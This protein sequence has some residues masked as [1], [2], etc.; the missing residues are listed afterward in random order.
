VYIDEMKEY[1]ELRRTEKEFLELDEV[2]DDM[3][4]SDDPWQ[5]DEGIEEALELADEMEPYHSVEI[6]GKIYTKDRL[7]ED[8]QTAQ[9][10]QDANLETT[11]AETIGKI[12]GNNQEDTLEEQA[13]VIEEL[14]IQ[15]ELDDFV[16]INDEE[17][18][19]QML[20]TWMNDNILEVKDMD[21]V[22]DLD[23]DKKDA[24]FQLEV[25]NEVSDYYIDEIE[26]LEELLEKDPSESFTFGDIEY[27][28]LQLETIIEDN[29]E[30]L[31][32]FVIQIKLADVDDMYFDDVT[33]SELDSDDQLEGL[34][35]VQN[36]VDCMDDDDVVV[37][38]TIE[39]SKQDLIDQLNQAYENTENQLV[40]KYEEIIN[41]TDLDSLNSFDLQN[42]VED[43]EVLPS[44][45][46]VDETVEIWGETLD[47]DGVEALIDEL[48]ALFNS[49]K[50]QELES[51][52]VL[53]LHNFFVYLNGTIQISDFYDLEMEINE[54]QSFYE[55]DDTITI[56]NI[57]LNDQ[58][59]EKLKFYTEIIRQEL[60]A[61]LDEDILPADELELLTS[62]LGES[63]LAEDM[64]T[65]EENYVAEAPDRINEPGIKKV[66]TDLEAGGD[67]DIETDDES[68][69]A[70][71]DISEDQ[72][73]E[74]I[75][76]TSALFLEIN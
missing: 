21:G 65:L 68:S 15:M 4:N 49:I 7:Y 53:D 25:P 3:E 6:E 14:I 74:E 19:I 5:F 26:E 1:Y 50:E 23:S 51:N 36:L 30:A 33:D 2:L 43:I 35:S 8:V 71:V 18:D 22:D 34:E 56:G 48:V 58:E 62:T 67:T 75:N 52:E 13:D 63:T 31:E 9:V 54:L 61:T 64:P 27:T 73:L 38:E 69:G 32:Q 70:V 57:E 47:I 60:S 46:D 42:L 17:Y 29:E 76:E 41:D 44:L 12:Q 24:E 40:R 66:D 72:G 55:T 10:S 20:E 28:R 39:F 11:L 59:I 45:L 37:L 16:V